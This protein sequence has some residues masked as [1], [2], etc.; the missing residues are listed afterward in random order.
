MR[1]AFEHPLAPALGCALLCVVYLLVAPATADMAAHSYRAW[2]FEHEGLTPWNAQ[3]YGGHHVLGYSLLFA[4]L[5]AAFGPA[6]VGVLSAIAAVALF[7]PLARA[8]AP[9][10]TAAA[11]ASWLFTAGVLSNVAIGRMPFL[12]GIALA[13]GAYSAGR[14]R[15][16]RAV[17]LPGAVRDARQPGRGRVPD[18]GRRGEADRRRAPRAAHRALARACRPS[19]AGS[20]STCCSPRAG[21]TA[22]PRP[23]SGRCS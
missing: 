7:V 1:R 22:S 11:A 4:P 16:A 14:C 17:R 20:G 10:P 2:L 21:R 18:A 6:M 3:W 13:V 15:A 5:A 23:R 19:R 8:A 12:L 9:S